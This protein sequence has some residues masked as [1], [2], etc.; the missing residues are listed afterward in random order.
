[1]AKPMR[2]APRPAG[3]ASLVTSIEEGLAS[4]GLEKANRDPTIL[5]RR[6]RMMHSLG[7]LLIDRA[8][9]INAPTQPTRAARSAP[10]KAAG[11]TTRK[12]SG[13]TTRKAAGGTTRKA[14][15][16]TNRQAAGGTNRQ[17][18]SATRASSRTRNPVVT[19]S[20]QAK[21]AQ[22][23]KRNAANQKRQATLAA[24]AAAA[25]GPAPATSQAIDGP[26]H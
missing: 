16:G 2:S 3:I 9:R 7:E 13:G 26:T 15:G 20:P 8:A 21:A 25:N 6:Q 18:A 4:L 14:A 22:T 23:R 19:L 1:M 17:A 24:K 11:G 5:G 10:R 12:A